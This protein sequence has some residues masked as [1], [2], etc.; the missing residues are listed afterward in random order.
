MYSATLILFILAGFIAQI[1][2]GTIGMAYGIS[3]N[4]MLLSYGL[5]PAVASYYVHTSEVFTSLASGISHLKFRN[6]DVRL[7]KK[8]VA[9]GVVGSIAGA[10]LLVSFP[11]GLA[12]IVVSL[13]L[14]AVGVA[15][16]VRSRKKTGARRDIYKYVPMIALPG[17]FLDAV[18]GGG[19]GP[20]VTSTLVAHGGNPRI[21]IGTVNLSEFFVTIS[22]TISFAIF[23]GMV[24][25]HIM[26]FITVGGLIAA[27][28][29]AYLCSRLPSK[30]I[31]VLVGLAVI[32]VSVRNII[33]KVVAV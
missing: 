27:P 23:L 26:L 22:Q 13:Y 28:L 15:I 14:A 33:Y 1:I 9:P 2:D 17:G 4:S 19:W 8:L 11:A 24:D 16:V 3:L 12:S 18:G 5:S 31:M 32:V 6:V 7:L 29:S 20:I 30:M 25:W 10:Y 21:S